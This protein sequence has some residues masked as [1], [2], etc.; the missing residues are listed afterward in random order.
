[1]AYGQNAHFV[2]VDSLCNE[3]WT[4]TLKPYVITE[5]FLVPQGCNLRI[6]SGVKVLCANNI[7]IVV[8]GRLQVFGGRQHPVKIGSIRQEGDY[9]N[10]PGQWGGIVFRN[11]SRGNRIDRAWI[12]N[13]SRI[14]VS[15]PGASEAQ[16]ADLTI[17]NSH[18]R[19]MM[20]VGLWCFNPLKVT[21]YNNVI[22][23]GAQFNFAGLAGGSY[24]LVH[25]TFAYNLNFANREAG[26]AFSDVIELPQGV[27]SGP[28][29]GIL[30][31]NIIAGGLDEE[32]IAIKTLP[33]TTGVGVAGNLLKSQQVIPDN[34]AVTTDYYLFKDQYSY[35][36][37]PDS[38]YAADSGGV[39]F[40]EYPINN[41][42]QLQ[43]DINRV[44]RLQDL[45]RV[46]PG[47]YHSIRNP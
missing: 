16:R 20:E 30:L 2:S 11:G 40:I 25:N 14:Q 45:P 36:F 29:D 10:T 27:F 47:A 17:S 9:L 46:S 26:V 33:A 43:L 34:Q 15:E 38:L 24:E 5:S 12:F 21:A 18:I 37:R 4:D 7:Y 19:N 28:Y 41:K 31:N 39:N 8:E 44:N 35:D 13:A 22:V 23:N 32:F 3:V 42:Q 6:D 1:M